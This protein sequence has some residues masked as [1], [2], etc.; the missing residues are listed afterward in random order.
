MHQ[1]LT[2][3]VYMKNDT[4]LNY[5][6]LA[7]VTIS[8][9]FLS[10]CGQSLEVESL[11]KRAD[12]LNNKLYAITVERDALKAKVEELSNT[13]TILFSNID[14]FLKVGKIEEAESALDILKA[15][16]PQA[17]ETKN[18][19][20][21]VSLFHAKIE[22]QREERSRLDAMSFKALKISP[23]V[24]TNEV[25]V[26]I[27]VPGFNKNFVFDRYNTSYHYKDADRDH[28]YVVLSLSATA[29]KGVSNP[30]LPGFALYLADGK[31]LKRISNFDL[32]FTRW[33]DYATYLGNY[34]DSR[35]DFTKN[36]TIPFTIG[37]HAS[38]EELLK[39][40]LYILATAKGCQSRNF[41]RFRQPP[42]YYSGLCSELAQTVP[43]DAL[44]SQEKSLILVRRI[45]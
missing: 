10:A 7:T 26:S 33:E 31:E 25:K 12:E 28:K 4:V 29:S 20:E 38:N 45:E 14:S 24:E 3:R 44:T 5:S 36:A 32:E 34:Q 19:Q 23:S 16:F 2:K 11:R 1:N 43:L 42:V 37:A 27:G 17:S 40:P 13:P 15:K 8:V 6:Y 41:E 22:K 35:N 39:R 21:L 9:F 30:N 18:A